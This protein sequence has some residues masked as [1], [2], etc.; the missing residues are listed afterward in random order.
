MDPRDRLLIKQWGSEQAQYFSQLAADPTLNLLDQI[1]YFD[2]IDKLRKRSYFKP[3]LD[4]NTN[5]YQ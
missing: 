2:I 5:P 1:K 3:K 4:W